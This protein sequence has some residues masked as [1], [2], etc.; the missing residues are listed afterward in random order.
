MLLFLLSVC[1]EILC[2]QT[3]ASEI[4]SHIPPPLVKTSPSPPECFLHDTSH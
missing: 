3:P 4:E 1:E 2:L